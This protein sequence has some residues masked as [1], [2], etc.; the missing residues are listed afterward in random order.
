MAQDTIRVG[1]IGSGFGQSAMI[2]G[3]R[4]TTG[5]EIV[6]LT[7]GRR[8][9][10][11]AAAREHGIPHA[12]DDYRVML[13]TVP[14]DLVA[15]VTPVY[16]HYP[17]TMDA[18][19]RG[20]HVLC[21]KPMAMNLGE[22]K[23]MYERARDKGVVHVIDHEL[24]F[25]PT[26]RRLQQL[27]AEGYLG[28]IYHVNI[29]NFGSLRADPNQPWSWWSSKEFGGGA[30]GAN[31]SHQVD[32]LRWWL[33]EFVAVEGH[34]ETYVKQRPDPQTGALKAVDS[35]D[36]FFFQ[37][38]FVS[39]ARVTV[40][41]SYVTRPGKGARVEIYG[42][43]GSLILDAE[44]RLWGFRAGD[45]ASTEFTVQDPLLEIPGVSQNVWSRSFIYQAREMVSAIREQRSV[46]WG[47][48]FR[49]GAQTQA[50]LDAIRRSHEERRWIEVEYIQ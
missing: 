49:D 3:F 36:Y 13:D 12:F 2:P 43:K 46:V 33:G 42:E 38:E 15:V 23:A 17:M 39:G 25:N 32:L 37:G 9:R 20:I 47:A 5:V 41:A 50:V 8:E 35:D 48:T 24:R 28:R 34:L 40:E 31:A 4:L 30:L 7:S 1:I 11:E 16:L 6:A 14:L 26:R 29:Q 45:S 10:A 44:D 27:L 21:E 22:A 18:L 19:D